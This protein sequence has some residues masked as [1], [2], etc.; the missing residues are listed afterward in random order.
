M[1]SQKRHFSWFFSNGQESN[2]IKIKLD[3]SLFRLIGVKFIAMKK[4]YLL[5]I[6]IFLVA[7]I[8]GAGVSYISSLTEKDFFLGESDN[9]LVITSLGSTTPL[10]SQVPEYL[11]KNLE[12]VPGVLACSPEV[13]SAGILPDKQGKIV[14]IRG[15][16]PSTFAAVDQRHIIVGEWFSDY[17]VDGQSGVLVGK[18]L[19][20]F[21]DIATGDELVIG[22]TI[23]DATL[24]VKVSGIIETGT[25]IDEELVLPLMGAKIIG[26]LDPGMTTLIRV[27]F[28][29]S[30]TDKQRIRQVVNTQF[31]VPVKIASLD[32]KAIGD[33]FKGDFIIRVLSYTDDLVT[34]Q[35]IKYNEIASFSLP[36]GFYFFEVISNPPSFSLVSQKIPKFVNASLAGPFLLYVEKT[37]EDSFISVRATLV[38]NDL[39]VPGHDLTLIDEFSGETETKTSD[40]QGVIE[41]TIGK[42]KFIT[43]SC[44]WSN[45]QWKRSF[46]VSND[47]DL[48]V[49]L[50]TILEF[51][52]KDALTLEP[53]TP[54]SGDPVLLTLWKK[55]GES[56]YNL[57]HSNLRVE[58]TSLTTLELIPGFYNLTL[59]HRGFARNYTFQQGFSNYRDFYLGSGLLN[60]HVVN[61]QGF[62]IQQALVNAT[63]I[64]DPAHVV[65]AFTDDDGSADLELQAG[66][67]YFLSIDSGNI[68][69]R[70][71]FFFDK[72]S[73][74]STSLDQSYPFTVTVYNGSS[75][76]NEGIS[77]TLLEMVGGDETYKQFTDSSGEV[78]FYLP[79]QRTR[80]LLVHHGEKVTPL[81]VSVRQTPHLGIPLGNLVFNLSAITPTGYPLDGVKIEVFNNTVNGSLSLVNTTTTGGRCLIEIPIDYGIVSA[82]TMTASFQAKNLSWSGSFKQSSRQEI[83]F[84]F[85]Y[86]REQAVFEFLDL[87][88]QPVYGLLVK[89]VPVSSHFNFSGSTG[90]TN[91]LGQVTFSNLNPGFYQLYYFWSVSQVHD[92][93]ISP[94][95]DNQPM[96]IEIRLPLISDD[97]RKAISDINST[98]IKWPGNRQYFVADTAEYTESFFS[99]SLSIITVTFFSFIVIISTISFLIVASMVSFPVFQQTADLKILKRLG[100]TNGQISLSVAV[101]FALA[102]LLSSIAGVVVGNLLVF[103]IADLGTADIAGILLVPRFDP[104]SLTLIVISACL[105]VFIRTVMEVNKTIKNV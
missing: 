73:S 55:E 61:N 59:D 30:R 72:S 43:L 105:T 17:S 91:D 97:P 13:L 104:L 75:R 26:G 94:I 40:E 102:A 49:D 89:I 22:S 18:K 64:A 78:T 70:F 34:V 11:I 35:Q 98:L 74:L 42:N 96:I 63:D 23:K 44:T 77:G 9:T 39:A 45:I 58:N 52:I 25:P 7:T 69:N 71:E 37:D 56:N 87:E 80:T 81:T 68:T 76:E 99:T 57:I 92:A 28:D 100:A 79:D 27:L 36:F 21:L 6:G 84:Y 86:P 14:I 32:G 29:A 88:D 46:F 51:S 48:T 82:I 10:T 1:P 62:A 67:N 101:Q 31:E 90:W 12:M 8:A 38:E 33:F 4:I 47:T 41:F 3:I 19:A 85:D 66:K 54:S 60:T 93:I 103:S 15:I 24:V 2:S 83:T 65:Q 53:I 5:L 95:D 20:E 16:N 50:S